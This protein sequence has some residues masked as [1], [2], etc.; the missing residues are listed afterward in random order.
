MRSEPVTP[1]DTQIDATVLR[2]TK[3]FDDA[4]KTFTG[5]SFSAA[6]AAEGTGLAAHEERI[7]PGSRYAAI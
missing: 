1:F 2:R 4:P 5:P 3:K 6:E 7:L